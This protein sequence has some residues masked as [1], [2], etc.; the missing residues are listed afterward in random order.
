MTITIKITDNKENP[1]INKLVEDVLGPG[2][3]SRTAYRLREQAGN[4]SAFALSAFEGDKLVGCVTFTAL[5]VGGESGYCLL[6]PL[7]INPKYRG[8][9]IGVNLMNKGCEY[10]RENNYKGVL[11]VGDLSY[12]ERAG[13]KSVNTDHV[14]FPGP[15][16]K[17]RI[18]GLELEEG[19]FRELKGDVCGEA[20]KD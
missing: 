12:Y 14:T 10:A 16:T 3:F 20:S 6:G 2:R 4:K 15:I 8:Q 19:A 11:L 13:F 17:T 18:L 5:T 1:A 7:V 9:Q